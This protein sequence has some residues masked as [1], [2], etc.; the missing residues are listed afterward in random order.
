MTDMHGTIVNIGRCNAKDTPTPDTSHTHTDI[1]R[2]IS[3]L[4]L[5]IYKMSETGENNPTENTP[6]TKRGIHAA[7]KAMTNLSDAKIAKLTQQIHDAC[8]SN[9]DDIPYYANM[10]D[11]MRVKRLTKNYVVSQLDKADS[12]MIVM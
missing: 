9:E 10:N 5:T 7:C 12:S 2:S 11:V 6:P 3:E 4:L 8:T 1:Q